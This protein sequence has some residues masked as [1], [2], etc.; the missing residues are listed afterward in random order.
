MSHLTS[1]SAFRSRHSP[2][3]N[4]EAGTSRR[5]G[6]DVPDAPCAALRKALGRPI[7]PGELLEREP[8]PRKGHG[9]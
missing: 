1:S 3:G 9:A 4:L 6:L 2:A 5:I 8:E 7:A